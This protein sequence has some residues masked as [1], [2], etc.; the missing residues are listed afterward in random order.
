MQ[1]APKQTASGLLADLKYLLLLRSFDLLASA[2]FSEKAQ[3]DRSGQGRGLTRQFLLVRCKP[4]DMTG[5]KTSVDFIVTRAVSAAGRLD[6][7]SKG[8]VLLTNDGYLQHLLSLRCYKLPRTYWVQVK[9]PLAA[10]AYTAPGLGLELVWQQDYETRG[11]SRYNRREAE[12]TKRKSKQAPLNLGHQW[13]RAGREWG[14]FKHLLWRYWGHQ[15]T[16]RG[17]RS[18]GCERALAH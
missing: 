15:D 8:L 18:L 11:I 1:A 6:Y 2:P 3:P 13:G 5:P 9:V 10:W 16:A 14:C 17:S 7:D 4:T 12:R